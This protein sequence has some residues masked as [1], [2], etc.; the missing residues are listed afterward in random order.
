MTVVDR[1][2]SPAVFRSWFPSLADQTYLASCSV[3]AASEPVL[4]ALR[5]MCADFAG[6]NPWPAFEQAVDAARG[7]FA[8]LIGANDE[9]VAV[10]PNVSTGVYQAASALVWRGSRRRVLTSPAEWPG[11]AH[12]WLA[13]RIRGCDP[14]FVDVT[15][16]H[17]ADAYLSV[18]DERVRAVSVPLVSYLN[19][20]RL[21]VANLA[22]AARAVDATVI[23]DASQGL[24]VQPVDVDELGCD[25]LVAS[26]SKYGLGLPGIAFLYAR[27]PA[28]G[29]RRPTL[30]GW[31][32][33][34]DPMALDPF[35]LDW[36]TSARR[37]ET[38]T[39]PVTAAYA[40]AAGLSLVGSLDLAAVRE[41]VLRL[42][43]RAA[44]R[45]TD[46]G[47]QVNLPAAEQRG[48][49]IALRDPHPERLAHWL[50]QQGIRTAPRGGLVRVA[51]HYF[52]TE[53]DVDAVT[54]AVRA[55]RHTPEGRPRP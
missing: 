7:R 36:P 11:V 6:G 31:L 15:G 40:A 3:A 53:A 47:E 4:D 32:G 21:P 12:V 35:T 38:G 55:Y 37:F 34:V 49:H 16:P 50:A 23:V 48:A 29:D 13:Q 26:P 41:H 24:G 8:R 54:D 33:R 17:P 2:L 18:L 10:V 52:N 22:R 30:T 51:C 1:S 46:A 19:G 5:Q 20:T 27:D 25:Y 43:A 42:T 14:I 45:L 39:P 28:G 9:Q 44:Q